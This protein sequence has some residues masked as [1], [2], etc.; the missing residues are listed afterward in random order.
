MIHSIHLIKRR[1]QGKTNA[2]VMPLMV[3]ALGL[4]VMGLLMFLNQ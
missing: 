4:L 3:L 1:L 2:N